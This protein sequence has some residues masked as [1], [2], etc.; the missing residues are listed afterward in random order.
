ME[1]GHL[2]TRSGLTYPEVSSKVYHDSFCPLGSSI[3]VRLL[4]VG[5]ASGLE[6]PLKGLQA[7]SRVSP[8][9]E[10]LPLASGQTRL[11]MAFP[12]FVKKLLYRSDS[13]VIPSYVGTGYTM[14][15]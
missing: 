11:G 13:V 9:V 2:L 6:Y 12:Q 15:S 7:Q 1:S 5:L 14:R 10:L 8:A 4:S 3:S